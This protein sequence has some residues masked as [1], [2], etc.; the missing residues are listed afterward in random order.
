[1]AK[2]SISILVHSAEKADRMVYINGR[3]YGE[4]DM[5]DGL[6]LVRAIQPDGVLLA[7]QG[8]E[9]FLRAPLGPSR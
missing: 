3:R 7:Y 9:H 2:L 5:V 8:E 1:M 4:G 6:Y